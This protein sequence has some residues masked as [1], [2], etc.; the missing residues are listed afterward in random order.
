VNTLQ[1]SAVRQRYARQPVLDGVDLDVEQGSFTAVLGASG[2]GK[3][4]LLRVIAGFER[5]ESGMVRLGDTMFDNGRTS[6]APER[7]KIGYVPQDG[8]LFP[9]L[10]VAAN[11][12]FGLRRSERR[13]TGALLDA[14][15]L[16]GLERRYPHQLSGGQQQR[17]ALA[18]ALAIEPEVVLLDEPFSSLDAAMR[19]S[20]RREVAQILRARGT[21]TVLVTH[22]QDEALSMADQVAVLRDGRIVVNGRPEELYRSPVDADL[23]GFLGEAN[24]LPGTIEGGVARTALGRLVLQDQIAAGWTGDDAAAVVLVRPEQLE[25]RSRT[26]VPAGGGI[27]ARVV[28]RA[29]FG[30][31]AVLR[32][33]PSARAGDDP[34]L[35]RVT[36][37]GAPRPGTD[38]LLTVR[39]PVMAWP[40]SRP[41]RS[42]PERASG[43]AAGEPS[44]RGDAAPG[45]PGEAPGAGPPA[46]YG[47]GRVR[48]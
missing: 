4:T 41:S 9:H 31:D 40:A 16:T 1:L 11:V 44:D 38:V 21:T 20:V 10:R 14:V 45:G 25:V 7:R 30:H 33:V 28:D 29:F 35:V 5:I 34:L 15:G 8:A 39:A 19:A 24:L 36:G 12:G 2:S 47:A 18:R 22:D 48:R 37:P 26:A 17:V 3:T 42:G 27:A 32:V 46:P 13:K 6:L 43:P 23:A